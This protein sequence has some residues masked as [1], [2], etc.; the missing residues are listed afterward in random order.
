MA[1][2]TTVNDLALKAFLVAYDLGNVLSFSGIAEGV[3][4]SN[5]L[6]RTDK[7]HYILTLYEKRVCAGDLP[8]FIDLMTHLARKGINCPVPVQ[9]RDGSILQE[10]E[11]KP[12][13][14]FSFLLGTSSLYPNN[15]KCQAAGNSLAKLH[16]YASGLTQ[17]RENALG[18]N[19]GKLY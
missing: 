1:V 17:S 5:F 11:G 16:L 6:L 13:A 12:C 10:L 7:G 14:I 19:D 3:E 8:F 2:Y 4:N 15:N 18:P 9:A